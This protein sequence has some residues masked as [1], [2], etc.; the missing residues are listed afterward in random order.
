MKDF[1]IREMKRDERVLLKSFLYEAIFQRDKNDLLSRNVIEKPELKIFIDRF[2]EKP[3]DHCL[4]AECEG[5]VVGAVWTRVL[6]GSIKGYGYVDSQT[7]EFAISLYEPY[8]NL[9]IGT[10]LMKSMLDVLRGKGYQQ[11]SLAVQKDNYAVKMYEAVGFHIAAES[12]E[13]FL[14]ICRLNQEEHL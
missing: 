8:R 13:E 7:P 4:V 5:K 11:T 10:A 1:R 3:D 6:D 2:G 14:M 12:E 9:G